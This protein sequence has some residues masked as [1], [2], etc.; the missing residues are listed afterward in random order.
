MAAI[1][2]YSLVVSYD[3]VHFEL[4]NPPVENFIGE[5]MF[6]PEVVAL[7]G[8]TQKHFWLN[9]DRIL[10][11]CSFFLMGFIAIFIN[12]RGGSFMSYLPLYLALLLPVY[13]IIKIS[14]ACLVAKFAHPKS[15]TYQ[16]KD[17][18]G[19]SIT[20]YKNVSD[21]MNFLDATLTAFRSRE[22][23]NGE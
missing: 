18:N 12:L 6:I 8:S 22:H 13:W 5:I 19:K 16:V 21:G 17:A 7:V 15:V 2:S 9:T 3:S 20:H 4:P 23:K 14:S 1:S 11:L 10:M